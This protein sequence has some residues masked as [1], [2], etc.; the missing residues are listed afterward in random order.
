METETLGR[1]GHNPDPAIDFCVE[2]DEI[3][4]I[5]SNLAKGLSGFGHEETYASLAKRVD[6]ALAFRVGGDEG[7][8]AAMQ[9]LRRLTYR[10]VPA[11][12]MSDT[13]LLDWLERAARNS[14]TGISFDWVPKVEDEPSGFRFM[15]RHMI[16]EPAKTLRA[17]IL[18]AMEDTA[19]REASEQSK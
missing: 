8:V 10:P 19:R 1:F 18:G 12:Q 15:R 9:A 3:E 6:A 5:A 13:E 11:G 17:A 4:A 2:V 7:A 14:Y 16:G